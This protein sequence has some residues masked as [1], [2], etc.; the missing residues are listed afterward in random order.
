MIVGK[1]VEVP[2]GNQKALFPPSP[3]ELAELKQQL[4]TLVGE[5]IEMEDHKKAADADY[6]K[7]LAHMWDEI[8]GLRA[9]IKTGGEA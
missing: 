7:R 1:L 5:Y 2:M 8:R 6:N 9:R 3:E 4:A